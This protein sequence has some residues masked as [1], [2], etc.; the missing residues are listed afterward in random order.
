MAFGAILV[1]CMSDENDEKP[2]DQK[3]PDDPFEIASGGVDPAKP[4]LSPEEE[5]RVRKE[6]QIK[7][8]ATIVCICKGINLGRVLKQMDG[9]ETVQDVNR[10]AGTGSGGCAGQRC[11]PRIKL[12]LRKKKE[13]EEKRK[14]AA[15]E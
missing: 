15:K 2:K 11:G 12:L 5:A 8:L 1:N 9:C 4:A 3:S 7:Q 10:R 14:Q 6:N 13:L